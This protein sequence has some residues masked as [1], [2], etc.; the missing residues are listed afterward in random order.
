MLGTADNGRQSQRADLELQKADRDSA[1]LE[2]KSSGQTV[3]RPTKLKEC[4]HES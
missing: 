4:L 1:D 2:S 3:Y